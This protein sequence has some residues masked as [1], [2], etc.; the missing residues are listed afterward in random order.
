MRIALA[1]LAAIVLFTASGFSAA[2]K[3]TTRLSVSSPSFTAPIDITDAGVLSLSNVYGGGFIGL[4]ASAPDNDKVTSFVVTFD[5]QA[6]DGVK[7]AAY[8]IGY[9]VDQ[10]TGDGFVYLPGRDEPPYRRNVSTILR[11]GQD[12]KWFRASDEWHAALKAHLR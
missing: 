10:Q 4:P 3:E 2:I 7:V 6:R 8:V 1:T 11:E 12:G 5:V 9:A